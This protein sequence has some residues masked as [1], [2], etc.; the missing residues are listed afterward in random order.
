MDTAHVFLDTEIFVSNNFHFESPL[1]EKLISLAQQETIFIHLTT[2]TVREIEARIISDIEQGL[3]HL[4][5]LQNKERAVKVLGLIPNTPFQIIP[6]RFEIAPIKRQI[7]DSFRSYLE[8]IRADI[9]PVTDVS[10]DEVFD[11]Y[12]RAVPP[13]G[14]SEKKHEF[15]DAFAL[16]GL[17]GWCNRTG[18]RVFVIS[19]DS[20]MRDACELSESFISLRSLQE[21]FDLIAK[22]VELYAVAL[23]L[24][25][26]HKREIED[27]LKDEFQDLLLFID[28]PESE[29]SDVEVQELHVIRELAIEVEDDHATFEL[30]VA[31]RFT[32]GISYAEYIVDDVPVLMRE[33]E[34]EKTVHLKG[35]V[36]LLYDREDS[37]AFQVEHVKFDDDSLLLDF[38]PSCDEVRFNPPSLSDTAFEFED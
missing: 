18:N 29:V 27:L 13:F 16:A 8:A 34:I 14:S 3:A 15:P 28:E 6:R 21:L 12:F 35:E 7:M 19:N 33:G 4:R 2:I 24:Y 31:V 26:E 11:K 25:T 37:D 5:T 22:E 32:A 23:N 10:I 20:D 17:Q 1:F 30:S 38:D 36:N 9:L